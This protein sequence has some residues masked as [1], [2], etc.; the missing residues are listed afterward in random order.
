MENETQSLSHGSD[1]DEHVALGWTWFHKHGS[2]RF[3]AAP[4]VGLS[5]PAFRIL[6]RRYGTQMAH[7]EMVDAAGFA[8]SP[9]YRKQFF[10]PKNSDTPPSSET[11]RPLVLQ[12]GGADIETLDDAVAVAL[13]DARCD[14]IELNCGCPQRCARKGGYG[15]FLLDAP[16]REH[17]LAIITRLSSRLTAAKVPLLVKMRVSTTTI[18]ARTSYYLH[19]FGHPPA[20][21]VFERVASTK[22]FHNSG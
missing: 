2:P 22:G 19:C 14:A 18:P 11:D 20:P 15:A 3:W 10:L 13:A 8:V 21:A 1:A 5:D 7:T 12:L 4:L 16:R 9:S 6:V 17:L